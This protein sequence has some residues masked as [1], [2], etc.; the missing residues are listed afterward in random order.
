MGMGLLLIND[1]S[2]KNTIN[3]RFSRFGNTIGLL[4]D[5]K[6]AKDGTRK[7]FRLKFKLVAVSS[8]A[9]S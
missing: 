2:R 4:S 5:W 6:E 7:N 9:G 3:R 8:T 1:I